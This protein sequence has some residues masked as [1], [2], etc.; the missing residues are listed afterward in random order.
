MQAMQSRIEYDLPAWDHTGIEVD[1]TA[2]IRAQ[3]E[4]QGW[5][6]QAFEK[7]ADDDWDGILK[8]AAIIEAAE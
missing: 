1:Q 6:N 8:V 3:I 4:R 7:Q 2:L 5:F